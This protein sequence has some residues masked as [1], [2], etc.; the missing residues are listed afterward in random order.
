MAESA[1]A[2]DLN[3]KNLSALEE[4]L[5]VEPLKFGETCKM[6]IPSQARKGRCRDLIGGTYEP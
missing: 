3:V 4:I 6:A 5:R 1:D 2:T